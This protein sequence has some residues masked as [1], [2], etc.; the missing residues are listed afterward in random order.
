M[1]E[2]QIPGP[3][4]VVIVVMIVLMMTSG[5]SVEVEVAGRTVKVYASVV[6]QGMLT[7]D[8]LAPECEAVIPSTPPVV[9][10]RVPLRVA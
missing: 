5:T 10:V 9:R 8:E 7:V 4:I 6:L 1:R 3:V 2:C